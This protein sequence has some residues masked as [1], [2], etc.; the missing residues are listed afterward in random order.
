MK[1]T[2]IL[3]ALLSLLSS[4]SSTTFRKHEDMLPDGT[5]KLTFLKKGKCESKEDKKSAYSDPR[6]AFDK[7]EEA[8]VLTQE[9]QKICVE[10]LKDK[11]EARAKELC[12]TPKFRLFGCEITQEQKTFSYQDVLV[13]YVKCGENP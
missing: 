10:S 13:C 8:E 11:A 1:Y 4:C 7:D 2:L 5:W 12:P 6:K 9:D 3:F